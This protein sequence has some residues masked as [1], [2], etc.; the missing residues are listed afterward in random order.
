V[1]DCFTPG[2][3]HKADC[4]LFMWKMVNIPAFI[5]EDFMTAKSNF[6]SS[7]TFEL[8]EIKRFNGSRD[9]IAKEWTDVDQELRYSDRF[10][11]QIKR[12]KDIV[13]EQLQEIINKEPDQ[14]KRAKQIYSYIQSWYQWDG[15]YGIFSDLGIKKAFSARKGNVGDINLSLI[16]AL[17]W[18]GIPAEPLILST[19]SNGVVTDLFPVISE[20][21][22]VVAK[23]TINGKDY[24]LDAVD[25][26]LPF[27]VLPER[28]LNGK[29]RWLGDKKS[30]WYDIHPT[31]RLKQYSLVNLTLNSDGTF[32]G[33]IEI[34]YSGYLAIRERIKIFDEGSEEKYAQ[35]LRERFN[36]FNID[37]IEFL[38]VDDI[39]STLRVKFHL[40]SE[41]LETGDFIVFN[42]LFI[43]EWMLNPFKSAKRSYPVDFGAPLDEIITVN[44]NY[45]D[46]YEIKSV[47]QRIAGVLPNQG[48]RYFVEFVNHP[49]RFTINSSFQVL[50][51]VF[52]S[53]EY[54]YLRTIFDNVVSATNSQIVF[55]L[56]E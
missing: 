31:V 13:N 30:E 19:R 3:G 42:P 16:A 11:K 18:A 10:G 2:G 21:N 41:M 55:E 53:Q 46:Q 54:P 45:P 17:Q 29:G 26:F 1:R 37:N 47:P 40:K 9:K 33:D 43:N 15:Y 38:H 20:F 24:L 12:G 23:T 56:S 6:L 27:G 35:K 44:I 5:E 36:S 48:G 52:S 25:D 14:L 50:K 51:T 32:D 28:C 4:A 34:N 22:Y 39:D 49:N 8:Q 7:I